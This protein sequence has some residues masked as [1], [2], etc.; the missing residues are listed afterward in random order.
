MD[1]KRE[2]IVERGKHGPKKLNT[3][4]KKIKNPTEEKNNSLLIQIKYK[5]KVK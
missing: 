4:I 3:Y 5:K 2:L 1:R